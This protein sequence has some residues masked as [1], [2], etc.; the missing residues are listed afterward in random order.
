MA[1]RRK[2]PDHKTDS[3]LMKPLNIAMVCPAIEGGTGTHLKEIIPRLMERGHQVTLVTSCE[4]RETIKANLVKTYKSWRFPV[5]AYGFMPL[6]MFDILR[7]L[8]GYDMVHIH[9]YTSFL[10]DYLTITCPLHKI[11]LI[12]TFHGSFH[13]AS[14]P[15]IYRLKKL[16]N[17]VMLRFQRFVDRFIVVS[18]A[19]EVEVIKRGIPA[20]KIG[21]IYNGVS[22]EYAKSR[23]PTDRGLNSSIILFLGRLTAS[24]NPELLLKA[25]SYVVQEDKDAKLILAGPDYGEK[26]KLENLTLKLELEKHVEFMGEVSEE[27]KKKLLASCAVFIHPSLQDIFALTVLEASAAGVPVVMFNMGANSEMVV[28]GKTGILVDDFTSKALGQAIS[29]L[30]HNKS[31]AERMGEEGQKYVLQKFPWEKTVNLLERTY[32][33]ITR[34]REVI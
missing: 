11:P 7:A 4:Y 23:R 24:K 6:A 27:E 3:P 19:E 15:K 25:M 31:I 13:Q 14:D 10:T 9:S 33:E 21:V 2:M 28:D 16:H 26:N 18:R 1:N 30:L 20:A 5:V 8:K 32:Y 34:G 29:K 22:P 17:W 12:I